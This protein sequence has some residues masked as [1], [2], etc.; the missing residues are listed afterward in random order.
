[1]CKIPVAPDNLY[2]TVEGDI[3]KADETI[4]ITEIRVTYHAKIPMDKKDQALRAIESHVAGCPA[5]QSVKDA[6][7]ILIDSDFEYVTD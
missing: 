1:M 3:G 5:Y 2:A 4:K 6:I 7:P